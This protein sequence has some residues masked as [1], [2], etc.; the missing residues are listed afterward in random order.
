MNSEGE[1]IMEKSVFKA[2][3]EEMRQE[4]YRFVPE[5]IEAIDSGDEESINKF[6]YYNPETASEMLKQR[7]GKFSP[8][9]RFE[10]ALYHYK[11]GGDHIGIIRQIIRRSLKLRDPNWREELPESVRDL[12]EFTVYRAACDSPE[13]V[14]GSL[15]WTLSKDIAE[16][17][18][19]YNNQN[20][21]VQLPQRIYKATI[22]A[23]KVIAYLGGRDEFEILQYRGVKDIKT[24]PIEGLSEKFKKVERKIAKLP[25]TDF[26][27]RYK[28]INEYF[29]EWYR[30]VG[31]RG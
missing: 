17:F 9:K 28:L 31:C 14:V 21:G 22:P 3:L 19:L 1:K 13:R 15:S 12:N 10:V 24:I 8:E 27:T 30:T 6:L 23:D 7:Y 25:D 20:A 29:G 16:W 18:V 4:K 5:A 11:D 2:I 26:D